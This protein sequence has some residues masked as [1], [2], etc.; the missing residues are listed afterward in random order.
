VVLVATGGEEAPPA[1][2]APTACLEAWNE[3]EQARSDGRHASGFHGY[4]RTQVAYLSREGE[5]L[6][7]EPAPGADCAVVFASN[8]LDSEPEFAVRVRGK[9]YWGG[10][11]AT[12]ARPRL[13]ALQAAAFDGANAELQPDGRLVAEEDAGGE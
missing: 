10:I 8:G 6:G 13:A 11:S 7:P 4:S 5:V 2:P 3:D 1:E 9:E 12:V